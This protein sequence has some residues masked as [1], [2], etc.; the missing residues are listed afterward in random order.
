MFRPV[1]EKV[2]LAGQILP[3]DVAEAAAQGVTMIVN[4]RPDGEAPGQPAG[5]EI[6]AAA[7]AAGVGYRHIPVAGG[8]TPDQV[9]DMAEAMAASEGKLLAFCTSGTRSAYL[10]ALARAQAG[11]DGDTIVRKGAAAGYDLSPLAGYLASRRAGSEPT[12]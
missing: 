12:R 3:G 1:D 10:W 9:N 7:H 8:F 2:L 4:N 5:A 11:E 6:E